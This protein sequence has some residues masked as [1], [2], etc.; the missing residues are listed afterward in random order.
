MDLPIYF[1]MS[2]MS[3]GGSNSFFTRIRFDA[4]LEEMVS[5]FI[6]KDFEANKVLETYKET[7]SL[8]A[9]PTLLE[10]DYEFDPNSNIV[11]LVPAVVCTNFYFMHPYVLSFRT[12]RNGFTFDFMDGSASCDIQHISLVNSEKGCFQWTLCLSK[13]KFETKCY[14]GM[15][16]CSVALAVEK[17]VWNS[18]DYCLSIR[19]T[20]CHKRTGC[21][22]HNPVPKECK[23]KREIE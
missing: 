16:P 5:H 20:V 13:F 19:C 21:K 9:D 12:N 1:M 15:K 22:T 10:G 23:C 2:G 7:F 18:E 4:L 3:G 8:F 6:K 11:V 14:Y 17:P